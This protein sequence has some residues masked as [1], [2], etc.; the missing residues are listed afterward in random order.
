M[1][2]DRLA[3]MIYAQNKAVGWWDDPCRCLAMKYGE[4]QCDIVAE[5]Q[6]MGVEV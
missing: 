2:Y 1:N 5:L 4:R 3:A 6:R